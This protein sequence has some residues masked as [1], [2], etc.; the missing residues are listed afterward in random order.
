MTTPSAPVRGRRAWLRP[1]L[2]VA[3]VAVAV[4]GIGGT[5]GMAIGA[6]VSPPAS[7]HRH[8]EWHD[9]FDHSSPAPV[10]PAGPAPGAPA[11]PAP[12][13]GPF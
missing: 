8:H 11:A 12:A 3:G 5:T 7:Y 4:A 1:L 6:A 13:P 9:R 2:V 10:P